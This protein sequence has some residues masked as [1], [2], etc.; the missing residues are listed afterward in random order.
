SVDIC[1]CHSLQE[2]PREKLVNGARVNYQES[3]PSPCLDFLYYHL[4][5]FIG[6]IAVQKPS[7]SKANQQY[8]ENQYCP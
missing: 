7:K 1:V 8:E 3:H 6:K 5:F 4:S 2:S